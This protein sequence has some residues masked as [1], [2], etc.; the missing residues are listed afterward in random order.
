MKLIGTDVMEKETKIKVLVA[1][2]AKLIAKG[3]ED[4]EKFEPVPQISFL[5]ETEVRFEGF[6]AEQ[7]PVNIAIEDNLIDIL[8]QIVDYCIDD[9]KK[10]YSECLSEEDEALSEAFDRG[11]YNPDAMPGHIYHLFRYL[12]DFTN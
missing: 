9:E 2:L 3:R 7:L 10:H 11:E 5:S 12:Q 8:R 4:K 6:P 1:A